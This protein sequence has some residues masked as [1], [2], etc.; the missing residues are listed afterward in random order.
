MAIPVW[1]GVGTP[2]H[3]AA[4]NITPTLPAVSLQTDDLLLLCCETA[5]QAPAT[6]AGWTLI[7]TQN[8]GVAG[9]V[10]SVAESVYFRRFVI[11]D[12]DPTITYS[13]DHILGIIHAFR[14]C[15]V[16]RLPYV[17]N[18]GNVDA[19]SNTAFSNGSGGAALEPDQL[20]VCVGGHGAD[21]ST[22]NYSGETNAS[23]T[24]L[25]ERSDDSTT[26]GVG[27]GLVVYTGSRAAGSTGTWGTITSTLANASA[28]AFTNIP[29]RPDIIMPKSF[30]PVPFQARGRNL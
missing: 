29:L 20:L 27:G 8:T 3:A 5:N 30:N 14:G 15:A 11:G 9:A 28:D 2:A 16:G 21:I 26:D 18:T 24:N 22:P 10:G 1:L 19:A 17:Q 13:Q 7:N 25:T 12:T 23:L 6:P 4:A